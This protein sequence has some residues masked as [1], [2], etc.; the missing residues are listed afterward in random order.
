MGHLPKEE[1]QRI[2]ESIDLVQLVESRG[3]GLKKQGS[4]FVGLCPFHEEKTPSF[5]VNPDKNL[6][7]CF[8]CG[9]GGDCFSF[10]MKHE[11]K[12]FRTAL[13]SLGGSP[14][15]GTSEQKPKPEKSITHPFDPSSE[16]LVGQV[17]EFY[18]KTLHNTPSAQAYLQSRGIDH[19]EVINQFNIGF[20]SRSLQGLIGRA[21]KTGKDERREQ[22]KQRGILT[23]KNR[24][25]FDGC[26]TFP[27]Y[28]LDGTL[29]TVY[30]RRTS[31]PHVKIKPHLYLPGAHRGVFN[32]PT[33]ETGQPI[34][35][36]ESI[37][38]ALTLWCADVRNVTS[39][40]GCHGF[41]NDMQ[42]GFKL[43][44]V[45]E[46]WIAYDGDHAGDNAAH[47]LAERLAEIGITVYRVPV[48]K[49]E[50]IN[51]YASGFED[52]KAAFD[53]LLKD[54]L[55]YQPKIAAG[56]VQ[57]MAEQPQP[58]KTE[59][60]PE[61]QAV[62]H[63]WDGKEL[64]L[65]FEDR[66]YVV[67]SVN[68]IKSFASMKVQIRITRN[69]LF[70]WYTVDLSDSRKR[71]QFIAAAA[72]DLHVPTDVIKREM[73][74]IFLA[75]EPIVQKAMEAANPEKTTDEVEPMTEAEYQEALAFLKS[76]N[77]NESLLK[78][79]QTIGLEGEDTNKLIGYLA[80]TSRLLDDPIALII[81]SSS[82]AGKTA[83]MDAIL[84]LMPTEQKERW[85][86]MTSASLFYVGRE[87]LCNKVLA[88]AEDEGMQNAQYSL[89]LFQSD[90]MLK[91]IT[92]AKDPHSNEL[93]SQIREVLGPVCIILITTEHE[94]DAE[95]ENRCLILSVDEDKAQTSLVHNAQR[96]ARSLQGKH[97]KRIAQRVKRKHHNAQR[98]LKPVEIYNPYV[99]QLTFNTEYL[100]SRRDNMK[101][102]CLIDAITFLHQYQRS[103]VSIEFDGEKVEHVET[104]VEDIRLANRLLSEVLVQSV[105]ELS[106]PTMRLLKLIYQMVMEKAEAHNKESGE[107]Q[108]TRR[109]VREYTKWKDSRLKDHMMKLTELEYLTLLQGS[110]GHVMVYELAWHGDETAT[111]YL[112][113][114]VDPASLSKKEVDPGKVKFEG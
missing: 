105:A 46:V 51:S 79:F 100:R 78:D 5:F 24:E 13:A 89:K 82:S 107:I 18:N 63:H 64:K 16:K 93:R 34:I 59:E 76:P 28:Q 40:F 25:F 104:S 52:R 91:L 112:P 73:G 102:L 84:D 62:P 30:G 92:I 108:F 97:I 103:H 68:T 88:I 44:E 48:P 39:S 75:V 83:L 70:Y 94:L 12:D 20:T 90:K 3:V 96:R 61:P 66:Q 23:A 41:T 111:H 17:L 36:C 21:P 35:V 7:H 81:Q 58:N 22:L 113:G 19:P 95:L 106:A 77:L 56:A 45:K 11:N 99:E 50:D 74:N 101:Y 8:E 69:K 60:A 114:L 110:R 109:H 15:V 57:P 33:L 4:D 67:Y 49:G 31:K 80:G 53:K 54:L 6:F 37:L 55:P 38:D 26:L 2:K 42:W 1:V 10:I 86:M 85:S 32:Y 47:Q 29:R 71:Q 43:R 14:L 72:S 98:L 27:V 9:A 65:F 87:E